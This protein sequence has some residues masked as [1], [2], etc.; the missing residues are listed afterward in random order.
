VADTSRPGEATQ[1]ADHDVAGGPD[2]LVE[3]NDPEHRRG[4]AP[5]RTH[6]GRA[7]P[8]PEIARGLALHFG[9]QHLSSLF[10]TRSQQVEIDEDA[11]R[12]FFAAVP[13]QEAGLDAFTRALWTA[14]ARLFTDKRM[15]EQTLVY[16]EPVAERFAPWPELDRAV[17]TA[18]REVLDPAG[19]LP[20]LARA[21]A[22]APY[23]IGLLV[24]SARWAAELGDT[25]GAIAF[26]EQ[27][28]AL[29][30]GRPDLER[31][32]GLVRVRV[33]DESGRALLERALIHA[34][35]DPEILRA[36]GREPPDAGT[37]H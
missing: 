16:V 13:A 22:A 17:A 33:G 2:R 12:A 1:E 3:V 31:E 25:A 20:F 6:R 19:A 5:A 4:R 15:P 18:Y 27:A 9:A 10:E 36:L 37:E 32:L 8:G 14:L 7:E 30:P 35:D 11:L 24:E 26:L 34:P 29:Q 23:D 21:R 28:L